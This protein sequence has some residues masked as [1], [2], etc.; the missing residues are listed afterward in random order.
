M[1]F[2]Q[3]LFARRARQP[4]VSEEIGR[5]IDRFTTATIMGIDRED[6]GRYPAKQHKVMAFHY[7]AIEYLCRQHD[8]DEVQTLG[9]FVVF[10]DRYFNMPVA[11]T[12]SITE[13]LQG[14]RDNPE[15][16]RY[17]DAGMDVFRR[18]HEQDER[19]APLEL[20]QMLKSP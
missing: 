9:L 15:Q 5:I 7:G 3:R 19:R 2:L 12:G 11:E 10:I 18:W 6:L 20:G 8:L 4:A 17:L 13:R 1:K 16:R 14:F